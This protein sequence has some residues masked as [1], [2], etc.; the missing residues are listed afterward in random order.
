MKNFLLPT[1]FSQG[2]INAIHY[3]LRLMEGTTCTFHFLS[4]YKAW[5]YTSGDLMMASSNESVYSC[6]ISESQ[7]KLEKLTTRLE[8]LFGEEDYTFNILTSYDVFTDA[9]NK[10]VEL[11]DI[12]L[13]IM[14]T[15][16]AETAAEKIFGSH[17]LRVIRKV[18]APVLV[19]P[20]GF[21]YHRPHHLL[22]SLQTTE[23]ITKDIFRPLNKLI[24]KHCFSLEILRISNIE[25]EN[26]EERRQNERIKKAFEIY[27]PHLHRISG[28]PIAEAINEVVAENEIDLHVLPVQ[29]E[30]FLERI[31]GSKLSRIIYST[32]VP[33]LILHGT[34]EENTNGKVNRNPSL[35]EI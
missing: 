2:S 20:E 28:I 22:L 25:E 14:G 12:D 15:N 35:Q 4:V 29:K 8:K 18:E 32:S 27:N 33:L 9:I 17:T 6:L 30:E 11:S 31:F 7:K 21:K 34:D 24:G 1:D 10:L 3:A 13:I 26:D 23:R 16:G 5:R 19:I